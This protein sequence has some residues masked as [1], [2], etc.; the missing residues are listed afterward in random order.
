MTNP[1]NIEK[2]VEKYELEVKGIRSSYEEMVNSHFNHIVA[3]SLGQMK[4]A[5]WL[6]KKNYAQGNLNDFLENEN[7]F[8]RF[9]NPLRYYLK[10]VKSNEEV[11]DLEMKT[12]N[13]YFGEFGYHPT[14]HIEKLKA[15]E[16]L[17]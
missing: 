6:M 4:N 9:S 17:K 12:R 3:N 13:G 1:E 16:E 10:L 11:R 14:S 2:L 8:L 5:T 7:I 15:R